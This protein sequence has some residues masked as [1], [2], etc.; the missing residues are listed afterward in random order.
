MID[1]PSCIFPPKDFGIL[2]EVSERK[3]E[4]ERREDDEEVKTTSDHPNTLRASRDQMSLKCLK[5][6]GYHIYST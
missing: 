5:Y 6:D 3:G 2:R 1:R 4:E